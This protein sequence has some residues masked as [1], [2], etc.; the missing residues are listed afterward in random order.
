MNVL[1]FSQAHPEER[2]AT[3][4]H[5]GSGVHERRPKC[6]G[7]LVRQSAQSGRGWQV[8][9]LSLRSTCLVPRQCAPMRNC[10]IRQKAERKIKTW[11]K[12]MIAWKKKTPPIV[13]ASSLH[14]LSSQAMYASAKLQN[15]AKRRK[16]D[17]N[18]EKIHDCLEKNPPYQ[19]LVLLSMR[20]VSVHQAKREDEEMCGSFCACTVMW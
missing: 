1:L 8:T 2:G 5:Q 11:K 17:K 9:S 13:V 20:V 10:K 19:L 4:H 18:A 7:C 16:K 3:L 14:L 15:S 12:V 6:R